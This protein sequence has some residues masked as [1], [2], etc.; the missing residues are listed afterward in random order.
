MSYYLSKLYLEN[1]R[2]YKDPSTLKFGRKLTLLYGKNSSGKSTLLKAI[3]LQKQSIQNDVDIFLNE[4]IGDPST[5]NL[6]TLSSNATGVPKKNAWIKLGLECSFIKKKS[7]KK[8]EVSIR[9]ITKK[10]V[11]KENFQILPEKVKL[12]SPS[13]NSEKFIEIKNDSS[14]SEIFLNKK[15]K[16]FYN[17]EIIFNKNKGAYKEL[18]EGFCKYQDKLLSR[19]KEIKEVN[20]KL[21]KIYKEETD[22]RKKEKKTE[23]DLRNIQYLKE[24]MDNYFSPPQK[25]RRYVPAVFWFLLDSGQEHFEFLNKKN[26]SFEKFLDYCEKDSIKYN[27]FLYKN[28]KIY[29]ER[30]F[31]DSLMLSELSD[32]KLMQKKG[33]RFRPD[34][35][36]WLCYCISDLNAENLPASEAKFFFPNMKRLSHFNDKN[37]V[38]EKILSVQEM[39]NNCSSFIKNTLNNTYIFSGIKEIP[40]V[41]N[42]APNPVDNFVGYSYENLHQ[43]IETNAKVINKWLKEFGFDFKAVIKTF[44]NG[45]KEI[46]FEK[47]NFEVNLRSGGL[48]AENILPILSQLVVSKED[49]LIFEEPE[50]RAHP[51]L[52]A[53]LSDL[54]INATNEKNNNQIIIESHS[55]NLL[56]GVL[57]AIRDN[58]ISSKDVSVKY[59]YI[60][61]GNSKI[62]DLEINERGVF[63]E[64][65]RDGF[66]VERLDLI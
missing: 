2:S 58:K 49:I 65:W 5:I 16:S 22:L 42:Q 17:S 12:Y 18:Y 24:E 9:G 35:I 3:Q 47:N 30:F 41:F 55:E 60:E 59:V 56:L 29:Y 27:R 31:E 28:N 37:E 62:Q 34:F 43:V 63:T 21:T 14:L 45:S 53:A 23:K 1:F 4:R 44:A 39:F 46:K 57:K 52:Q 51:K 10:F 50:R 26:I 7:E 33:Y 64:P 8:E 54:L 36:A 66:F 40:L 13:D 48:G 25:D 19:F 20:E 61:N 38:M 15:I 6:G 32:R 11:Q